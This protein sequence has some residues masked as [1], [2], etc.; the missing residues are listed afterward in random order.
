MGTESCR[1][2]LDCHIR[3]AQHLSA[4]LIEAEPTCSCINQRIEVSSG[5]PWP[6]AF[7]P[8]KQSHDKCQNFTT[9]S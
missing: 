8:E 5:L 3:P 7:M 9:S 6:E 4:V 1:G 2:S